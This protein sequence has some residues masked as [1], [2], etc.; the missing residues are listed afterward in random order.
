MRLKV[1]TVRLSAAAVADYRHILRWTLENFG[2]AQAHAYAGT[3]LSALK[4]LSEGPAIT[5]VKQRSEIGAN[6]WTLHVARKRRKGRHFIMFRVHSAQGQN[7][8][9]VLRVLHDSMELERHLPPPQRAVR[10]D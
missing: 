10:R 1:W 3:L 5:G 8:I 4:D 6:I 9:D 2:S 7:G